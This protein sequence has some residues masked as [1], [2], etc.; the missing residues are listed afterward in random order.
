MVTSLGYA[1]SSAKIPSVSWMTMLA[2]TVTVWSSLISPRSTLSI[3]ATA[4]AIL[5]TL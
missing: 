2:D 3:T 5:L 1:P 4:T